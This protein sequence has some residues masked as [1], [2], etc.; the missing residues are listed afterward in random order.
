MTRSEEIAQFLRVAGWEDATHIPLAGDADARRYIRLRRGNGETAILMDAPPAPDD[1]TIRFVRIDEHL[2]RVG[3]SAPAIAAQHPERGLLLLEDFGDAQFAAV[4]RDAPRKTEELY[5]AAV[6]L[7]IDL[8][9]KPSPDHLPCYDPAAYPPLI[10]PV[11]DWYLAQGS[12]APDGA[13]EH[14]VQ[15]LDPLMRRH[16]QTQQPVLCLRDYHV[17]NLIWL[18]ERG[19]VQRVGLLDFQDAFIGHPA[20]DLVSLLEDARRDTSPELRERLLRHFLNETGFD[21]D[22]LRVACAVL[23]AQ[24]NLRILGI[25]ARLSLHVGKPRYIAL[26]P[27]VWSHLQNDLSHPALAPL[28]DAVA[29]WLPEPTPD[30][31]DQLRRP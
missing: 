23:A 21:E 7:L 19:D 8:S 31:L 28:R 10:A 2:T 22:S 18:P 17:E 20:Y 1:S 5:L 25:F 12:V 6:D 27:R 9:R 24:R 11:W 4:M 29:Q 26:I 3:L 16:C 14:L 13:A 15:A 30:Y